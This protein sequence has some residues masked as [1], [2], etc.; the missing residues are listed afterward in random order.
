MGFKAIRKEDISDCKDLTVS[1]SGM[2][3]PNIYGK[4]KP[5]IGI[6]VEVKIINTNILHQEK[7]FSQDSWDGEAGY[8]KEN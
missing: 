5:Y 8:S 7:T 2:S 6:L 1:Q 3:N 4:T